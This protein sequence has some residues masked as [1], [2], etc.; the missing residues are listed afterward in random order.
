MFDSIVENIKKPVYLSLLF[1]IYFTYFLILF[2]I[3]QTN[4]F[5]V[6]YFSKFLQAFIAVFL[7]IRFHPFRKHQ[8][9]DFD[10]RIIFGSALLILSDLGVTSVIENILNNNKNMLMEYISERK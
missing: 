10:D 3:Y 4:P 7:I 6:R 9:R 2:G 1:V 5:Y 8:L